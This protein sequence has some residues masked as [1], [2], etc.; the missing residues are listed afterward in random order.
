MKPVSIILLACFYI[1]AAASVAADSA[2]AAAAPVNPD[3]AAGITELTVDQAVSGHPGGFALLT[4]GQ[5]QYVAYYN[6]ARRMCVAQRRLGEKEWTITG[7]DSVVGW[8][9][10]N[11]I[12]MAFDRDGRLHLSGNMHVDPLVYFR[13]EKPDDASSLRRM[14]GMTGRRESRATYPRF[15]Y[16]PGGALVFSY[17]DGESGRGDTLYNIYDEK[18]RAWRRLLD[19]PLFDGRGEMSAYPAGPDLGPDGY[20]HLTW[21][22]RDTMAAETNHDLGYARSRDLVHW[23]TV[24]GAPVRLPV[25]ISTP[26]VIVD[27]VPVEGGIINGSGLA[28]FDHQKNVVIAYHKFDAAGLTQLYLARF[29]DGRWQSTQASRWNYRWYFHGGGSLVAE[30]RHGA[31]APRGDKLAISIRH[32]GLGSGLWL[33][34]PRTLQLIRKIPSGEPALPARLRKP[35]SPFPGMEVRT[36]GD[37]SPVKTPGANYRLHWESLPNYRDRPRPQPWPEPATLRVV[38]LPLP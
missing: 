35:Q 28:G 24:A 22:W 12:R 32:P 38:V 36:A 9:S 15:F 18:T 5:Y 10:H 21:V 16:S 23:E 27:P 34:E 37:S 4:R 11:Y 3:L 19:Q 13:G 30:I 7:L 29:I 6:A 25:T 17:R 2:P 33:V 26:G 20:Y 31:P 14:P 1:S 8:D